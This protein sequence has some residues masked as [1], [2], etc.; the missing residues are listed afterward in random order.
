MNPPTVTHHVTLNREISFVL[1]LS[2]SLILGAQK[3]IIGI[4]TPG[5]ISASFGI[6]VFWCGI[7]VSTPLEEV[8]C[9]WRDL[10]ILL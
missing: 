2:R 8:I 5:S 4:E 9:F 10:P 3:P 1:L 6:H 7:L